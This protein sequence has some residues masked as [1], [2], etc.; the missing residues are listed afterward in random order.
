[1]GIHHPTR[2][3]SD[4]SCPRTSPGSRSR[5]S[6][7]RRASPSWYF[8]AVTLIFHRA[9]SGAYAT[10]VPA[11]GPLGLEY[12][13]PIGDPRNGRVLSATRVMTT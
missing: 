8:P 2:A 4:R 7:R 12:L 5:R 9:R 6:L 1:M 3:S 10:E 11:I 13:D